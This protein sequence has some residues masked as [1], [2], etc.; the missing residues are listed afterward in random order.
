ML[1][2]IPL[3]PAVFS[4][5]NCPACGAV[6]NGARFPKLMLLVTALGVFPGC[7][8]G[9]SPPENSGNPYENAQGGAGAA[10][11]QIAAPKADHAASTAD[12]R[13]SSRS[14]DRQVARAEAGQSPATFPPA[15]ASGPQ[16]GPLVPATTGPLAPETD[17]TPDEPFRGKK[18]QARNAAS[19][20]TRSRQAGLTSE[21]AQ[22][23]IERLGGKVRHDDTLPGAPIV[24]VDFSGTRLDNAGLRTVAGLTTLKSL[25]LK[26]TQITGA[27]LQSL[28]G[29]QELRLLC[30]DGTRV[31]NEDLRHLQSFSKLEQVSAYGTR[32]NGLGINALKK[33]LPNLKFLH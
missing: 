5:P 16:S 26:N 9:G 11:V 21:Q 19:N 7:G 14:P 10:P 22:T 24:S 20:P 6:M 8:T 25:N 3:Q 23:M 28:T 32:I 30:L 33:A 29:L 2:E 12:D 4:S 18:R 31:R 1:N 17:G 13:R 15:N 27:G